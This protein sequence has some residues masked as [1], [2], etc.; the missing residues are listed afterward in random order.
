M[1]KGRQVHLRV[2]YLEIAESHLGF[3]VN[4]EVCLTPSFPTNI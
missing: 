4:T 2:F 1:G 3:D